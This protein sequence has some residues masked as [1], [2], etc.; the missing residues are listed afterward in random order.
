MQL[1]RWVEIRPSCVQWEWRWMV[2]IHHD[3]LKNGH[4]KWLFDL[5]VAW[6]KTLKNSMRRTENSSYF[7]TFSSNFETLSHLQLLQ[8]SEILPLGF[9]CPGWL[10]VYTNIIVNINR[11]LAQWTKKTVNCS[12]WW[13]RSEPPYQ[14]SEGVFFSFS[15]SAVCRNITV[16]ICNIQY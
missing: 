5:L 9:S 2:K 11:E 6:V 1:L 16:D 12:E 10:T 7:L 4:A 3:F 14:V 15:F 8:R 13:Y